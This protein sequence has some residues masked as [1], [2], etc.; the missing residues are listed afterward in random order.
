MQVRSLAAGPA[1][2]RTL[3]YSCEVS[4]T[5]NEHMTWQ[6]LPIFKLCILKYSLI[7]APD[8]FASEVHPSDVACMIA[9]LASFV[10]IFTRPTVK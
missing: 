7:S 6:T 8:P 3:L 1:S 4:C 2:D 9:L 5:A 10:A